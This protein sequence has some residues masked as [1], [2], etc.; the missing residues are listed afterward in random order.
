MQP[1][2]RYTASASGLGRPSSGVHTSKPSLV[3]TEADIQ[4]RLKM[5][6][7]VQLE[8]IRNK[9]IGKRLFA[10][11]ESSRSTCTQLGIDSSS[12]A[13]QHVVD[14]GED[15][16]LAGK[17]SLTVHI[18]QTTVIW[19]DSGAHNPPSSYSP[20]FPRWWQLG[21]WRTWHTALKDSF[22]PTGLTSSCSPPDQS[23]RKCAWWGDLGCSLWACPKAN[24]NEAADATRRLD[25]IDP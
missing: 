25:T 13:V 22:E 8:I 15:I 5:L 10:S 6:Q 24:I 1:P 9:P 18:H 14:N 16:R 20:S 19:S 21:C 7:P 17:L 11:H 12:E 3:S 23:H 4:S 2:S